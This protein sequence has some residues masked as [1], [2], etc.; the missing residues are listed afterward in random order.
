MR[1]LSSAAGADGGEMAGK[2]VNIMSIAGLG[3]RKWKTF[4]ALA[5]LPGK[6][7]A[8]ASSLIHISCG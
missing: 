1:G 3:A 2:S 6:S 5:Q 4:M 8:A 7:V